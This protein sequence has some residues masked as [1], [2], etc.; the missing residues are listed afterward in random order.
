MAPPTLPLDK[1]Q[2]LEHKSTSKTVAAAAETAFGISGFLLLRKNNTQLTIAL[3]SAFKK[4]LRRLHLFPLPHL[5][6]ANMRFST[7]FL[8]ATLALAGS[9][10]SFVSFLRVWRR[11][12]ASGE[13]QRELGRDVGD[14]ERASSDRRT[15]RFATVVSYSLPLDCSLPPPLHPS[16]LRR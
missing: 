1:T 15:T 16:A 11:A 9:S 8:A 5:F 12:G 7:F 2:K 13:P 4:P 14:S 6:K 10:K 3:S